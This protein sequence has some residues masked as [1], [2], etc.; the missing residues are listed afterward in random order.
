M[1]VAEQIALSLKPKEVQKQPSHASP[2]S[3]MCSSGSG[4]SLDNTTNIFSQGDTISI[5]SQGETDNEVTLN[6]PNS[7]TNSVIDVS[8]VND[9]SVTHSAEI[10]LNSMPKNHIVEPLL[11]KDKL[12]RADSKTSQE[13]FDAPSYIRPVSSMKNYFETVAEANADSNVYKA[14]GT[15]IGKVEGKKLYGNGEMTVEDETNIITNEVSPKLNALSEGDIVKLRVA[16]E[17]LNGS[18]E[19]TI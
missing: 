8:D 14:V 19:T 15:K 11:E 17:S 2:T 3:Q 10:P 12:E 13:F 6:G 1:A 9:E 18:V 16:S 5:T 4:Y 7:F